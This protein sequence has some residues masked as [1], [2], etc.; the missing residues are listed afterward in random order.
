M[1]SLCAK[2]CLLVAPQHAL[3]RRYTSRGSQTAAGIPANQS[4]LLC[5]AQSSRQQS[6]D[7]LNGSRCQSLLLEAIQE[8]AHIF[9]RQSTQRRATQP[10]LDVPPIQVQVGLIRRFP[11]TS[12]LLPLQPMLHPR[13]QVHRAAA[14]LI[15]RTLLRHLLF[16]QDAANRMILP[17]V[18][19]AELRVPLSRAPDDIAPLIAS[20]LALVDVFASASHQDPSSFVLR[21]CENLTALLTA[22]FSSVADVGPNLS[23]L[24]FC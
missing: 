9:L 22:H 10:G 23:Y 16:Y 24:I 3:L 13:R 5:R 6:V 21:F 4:F 1:K 20:I 14:R 18:N 2:A 8:D 7:S 19:I 17:S 15:G 12:A 11:H